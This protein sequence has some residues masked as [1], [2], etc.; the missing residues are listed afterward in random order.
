MAAACQKSFALVQH[1]LLTATQ[2]LAAGSYGLTRVSQ[3]DDE[4]ADD[5]ARL[6]VALPF[7]LTQC[8]FLFARELYSVF[9]NWTGTPSTPPSFGGHS[10]S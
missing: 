7:G 5:Q 1:R 4:H 8:L 10:I 9:V 6:C 2:Q 3:Q